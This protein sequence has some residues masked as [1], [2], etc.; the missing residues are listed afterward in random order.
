MTLKKFFKTNL[1]VSLVITLSLIIIINNF[2]R[3][4]NNNSVYEFDAWLSNWQGGFVRRGIPGE[5]LFQIHQIF[6]LHLGWL[7]FIFVTILYFSFYLV[8][9]NLIKKINLNKLF[10][11]IIFSPI[12]FYFPVFNSKGSG[13]KEIFF[14]CLFALFCYALP[15]LT[16]VQAKYILIF[17]MLLV[18]LSHE[19]LIFYFT[20]LV[21][22]FLLFFNFK[23]FKDLAFNL[24]P[25]FFIALGLLFL[26]YNFNGSEGHVVDICNSVKNYVSAKCEENGQ[27]AALGFIKN[28]QWNVTFTETIG[29]DK[30]TFGLPL[31]PKYFLIYGIGFIV[32]FFPLII[33]YSKLKLI[34]NRISL[35][36]LHPFLFFLIPLFITAPIY[37]AGFDWGRYLYT[38]Y[39]CSMIL[40]IFCICNNIFNY[41]Y[42]VITKKE[43]I[44]IKWLFI[45]IIIIYGFSWTVPLCCELN[46]KPGIS[47]VFS[48]A[49][50]YYNANWMVK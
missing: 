15:K 31:F 42:E 45:I 39:M 33:L 40:V 46:F 9:F 8:F 27:I 17:I 30:N 6:S 37:Y 4:F 22:P 25:L 28:V 16:K 23:D 32:G 3:F 12:G 2:F 14:L 18:G 38:S 1:T 47:S 7:V 13:Q 34:G 48:K 35:L 41:T 49:I 26:T 5:I 43:N 50:S 19:G 21:I 11:F 44:F 24:T 29:R 10:T 36:N 20:Y